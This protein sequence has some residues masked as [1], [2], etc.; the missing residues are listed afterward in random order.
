MFSIRESG[1]N[2]I[3][4]RVISFTYIFEL[5][6]NSDH[7]MFSISGFT[8]WFLFL[9]IL[10][11]ALIAICIF[12]ISLVTCS[13]CCI[14][15]E[16]PIKPNSTSLTPGTDFRP[17]IGNQNTDRSSGQST[18]AATNSNKESTA[19]NRFSIIY[20]EVPETIV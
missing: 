8:F 15:L 20:H 3:G 13:D 6:V 17:S 14:K 2:T 1:I 16:M 12:C 10:G 19:I 18:L 7:N 5:K 11:V 4:S 9:I